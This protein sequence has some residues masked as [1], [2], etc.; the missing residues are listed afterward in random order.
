MTSNLTGRWIISL[1]GASGMRYAL[2]LL[3][4]LNQHPEVSELLVI[5]S[6]AAHRVLQEEEN[7]K[8][9]FSSLSSAALLGCESRKI[10][11]LSPRDIAAPI[12]SGS[13]PSDGMVIVPC[14]MATLA[15]V[16]H[17]IQQNLIHR[18][19]DVILKE[20][21]NLIIVPRETPLSAVHLEN[22]L[23]LS[24]LGVQ[25]VAAMPGFYHNPKSID[26]LIDM[27]CMKIMDCMRLSNDA[28]RRWSGGSA[29]QTT[30]LKAVR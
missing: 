28:A 3:T 23:K 20:R 25:V 29:P 19:A 22:M 1:T 26:D 17:G 24:N 9:S 13:F 4:K 10:R 2:H 30:S 27:Q 5:V 15:A 7:L 21:R 16:S 6:E 8:L 12:A 14:S 18:A 11:F